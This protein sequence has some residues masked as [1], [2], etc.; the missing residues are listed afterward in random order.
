MRK[1]NRRERYIVYGASVVVALMMLH[2]VI[3]SPLSDS[4]K[5]MARVLAAKIRISGEMLTLASEYG[6][7]KKN[8]A[9]SPSGLSGRTTGFTLFSFLDKQA[10]EAGMKEHITY[11]KPST[12]TPKNSPYKIA[13]VEL[14]FQDITTEQLT[15]YL[16]K[17]ET[18]KNQVFV[19]RLSVSKD[20]KV[21]GLINAVLQVEATEI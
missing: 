15:T 18:S 1:L 11:M 20:T 2:W 3:L 5:R 16:H 7:I 19:K 13:Q 8:A 12:T 21:L 14:K 10:G 6:R 4:R 9:A 17:V